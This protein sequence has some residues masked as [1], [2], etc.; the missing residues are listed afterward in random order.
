MFVILSKNEAWER[1]INGT[2]DGVYKLSLIRSEL[3]LTD[4]CL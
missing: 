1:C 4:N 2:Q 3:N